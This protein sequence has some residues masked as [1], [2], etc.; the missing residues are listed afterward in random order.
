MDIELRLARLERS[1][2][3]L[4]RIVSVLA[5]GMVVL[6]VLLFM[7]A[8]QTVAAQAGEVRARAFI[9]EDDTGAMI[10]SF[11]V[12]RTGQPILS[13]W[14][15]AGAGV[16]DP[17]EPRLSMSVA[18]TANGGGAYIAVGDMSTGEAFM[19]TYRDGRQPFIQLHRPGGQVSWSAP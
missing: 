19:R 15:G 3:Q 10:G 8:P 1:N 14:E 12:G 11:G 5:M 17:A 2:R 18:A 6:A 13:M 4:H 9:L 7:S 16:M